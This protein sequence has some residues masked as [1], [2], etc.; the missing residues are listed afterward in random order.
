MCRTDPAVS[1]D[2]S[3]ATAGTASADPPVPVYRVV[4][5]VEFAYLS[6]TGDYG[7][8][9]SY[10][11]KYFALSLSGAQAFARHPMNSGS[12]VTQTPIPQCIVDRGWLFVDLGTHGAGS[13][14]YFSEPQLPTVYA[15][16][17]PPV[18]V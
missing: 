2:A 3:G 6:A 1:E 17:T 18:V 7:S 8:N 5:I 14:V 9:P 11:G 16:M 4:D 15:A 13:S 12:R 10:S